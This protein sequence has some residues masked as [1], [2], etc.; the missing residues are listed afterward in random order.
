M[1]SFKIMT[2]HCFVKGFKTEENSMLNLHYNQQLLIAP[3]CNVR[4]YRITLDSFDQK[5]HYG[6]EFVA[7]KCLSSLSRVG[8]VLFALFL[9]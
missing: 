2:E 5:K 3:S 6:R 4:Y 9:P 1:M 7:N 8:N